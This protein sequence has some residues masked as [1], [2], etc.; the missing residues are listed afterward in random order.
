[1]EKGLRV[2]FW[3]E[4]PRDHERAALLDDLLAAVDAPVTACTTW[5]AAAAAAFP[6]SRPW[7]VVVRDDQRVWAAAPLARRRHRGHVGLTLLGD[8]VSDYG[9]LP[10][11]DERSADLLASAL[12]ARLGELRTGWTLAMHQL[13]AQDPVAVRLAARLRRTRLQP[14]R[15]APRTVL[16]DRD[17][18]SY[19]SRNLRKSARNRRNR[20][21]RDGHAPQLELLHAPE[22]V[23]GVLDELTVVCRQ[24]ER[25]MVGRSHLDE[26]GRE[27]FLRE[28]ALALAAEGR[29]ELAVLR[30]GGQVAAY[31]VNF[32]DGPTYRVWNAHH[33]PGWAEYSPGQVLDYALVE[34]VLA[35]RRYTTIDWMMGMEGYKLRLANASAPSAELLAWSSPALGMAAFGTHLVRGRLEV[36]AAQDQ[37]AADLLDALRTGR[38]RL[39][40]GRLLRRAPDALAP[41]S[42]AR[43]QVELAPWTRPEATAREVAEA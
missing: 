12:A 25:E 38:G 4:L 2:E 17:I 30:A 11:R 21:E 14:G 9:C 24:R 27:R 31:S 34:R 37:R 40:K 10:A 16:A 1:M 5:L 22:E 33:A 43:P 28:V 23:R 36:A 20:L 6:A 8:G 15:Q 42:A 3:P 19:L 35:D 18:T 29:L 7:I 13:P 39:Q 41:A 32:L 26:P